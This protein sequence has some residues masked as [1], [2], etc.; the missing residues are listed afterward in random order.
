MLIPGAGKKIIPMVIQPAKCQVPFFCLCPQI[1]VLPGNWLR[2]YES[3]CAQGIETGPLHLCFS[4][5]KEP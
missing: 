2:M 1:P 4:F 5:V 3:C